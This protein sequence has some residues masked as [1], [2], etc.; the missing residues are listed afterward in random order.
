MPP[1]RAHLSC[2]AGQSC[3]QPWA[4]SESSLSPPGTKPGAEL[5]SLTSAE[6]SRASPCPESQG[7]RRQV[8]RGGIHWVAVTEPRLSMLQTGL[9]RNIKYA[10]PSLLLS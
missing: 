7:Q 9:G 4:S 1:A 6:Q 8:L 2:V 10:F 5:G 3:W